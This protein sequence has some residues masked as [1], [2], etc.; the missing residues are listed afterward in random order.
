MTLGSRVGVHLPAEMHESL[1]D[2]LARVQTAFGVVDEMVLAQMSPADIQRVIAE[3]H[4]SASINDVE[5]QNLLDEL[6]LVRG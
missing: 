2:Y 1:M 3:A 4:R 6:Q 5:Y